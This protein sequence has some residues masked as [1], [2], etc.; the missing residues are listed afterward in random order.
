M[1][2]DP[3]LESDSTPIIDLPLC[4][5]RLSHNAAFPWIILIPQKEGLVE[6]ID[7]MPAD[8]QQLMHE[9]AIASQVMHH[10]FCPTKLNVAALGNMVPQLHIHV[11]ARYETDA[12]WPRPVWNS[13]VSETY[14]SVMKSERI[15]HLRKAFTN[16]PQSVSLSPLKQ[17]YD[18]SLEAAQDG[19]DWDL[20][21]Q[22]A[23]KVQEETEEVLAELKK[24]DSSSRQEALREEM[25][26][27]FFACVV[28][29][30]HC[31]VDPEDAILGGIKKFT[32]RYNRLKSFADERGISLQNTPPSELSALWQKL[33]KEGT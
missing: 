22:A 30:R 16:R 31:Q 32:K 29:A 8:Q 14:N 4:Q 21:I 20:P 24:P 11:I 3:R 23:S 28:L 12:A 18:L 26:D 13:G 10:L 15:D 1:L 17:A 9:I 25:G 6:L 19:F 27:L 5:V 2:L 7:L 33:K